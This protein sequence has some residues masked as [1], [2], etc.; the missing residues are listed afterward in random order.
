MYAVVPVKAFHLGKQRLADC[1]DHAQRAALCQA[2]C[3]DV[4]TV[5]QASAQ[6]SQ[7]FLLANDIGLRALAEQHGAQLVMESELNAHGLNPALNA[8]LLKQ[9]KR[10]EACFIAHSD[11]PLLHQNE[12]QHIATQARGE[13]I[14]LVSDRH[15]TGTNILAGHWNPE[16][17][18]CFGINSLA[19][20][21]QQARLQQ[22][23]VDV[24]QLQG[25]S[26]DIDRAQDLFEASQDNPAT[27]GTHTRALLGQIGL[28]NPMLSEPI[29]S[30]ADS[31]SA[32]QWVLG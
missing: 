16:V 11:L 4:L 29:L 2:M 27:F 31:Y 14:V 22:A 18:L 9:R 1:L 28:L 5:L 8:L 32:E 3:Q 13:Q 24:V 10:G 30:V 26:W 19:K 12:V 21:Q 20:H 25:A 23:D 6:F 7:C 17:P 15:G